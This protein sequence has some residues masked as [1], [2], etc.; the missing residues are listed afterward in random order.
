[1]KRGNL[2]IKNVLVY[3]HISLWER[4]LAMTLELVLKLRNQGHNVFLVL[5]QSELHACPANPNHHLTFC[6]KCRLQSKNL[7]ETL[8]PDDVQIVKLLDNL[9][10]VKKFHVHDFENQKGF[11]NLTHREAPL[12]HLVLSQLVDDVSDLKISLG[13]LRTR[14]IELLNMAVNLFDWSVDTLERLNIDEVYVW[15]GRRC[16]DGPVLHAAGLLGIAK[17][18]F[19]SGATQDRIF[20][21][22]NALHSL[23]EWRRS[24]DFFCNQHSIETIRKL[25]NRFFVDQASNKNPFYGSEGIMNVGEKSKMSIFTSTLWENF[26]LPEFKSLPSDFANPYDLIERVCLDARLVEQFDIT[27]RWHPNLVS[28]GPYEQDEI[29][30][31]MKSTPMVHHLPPKSEVNSYSLL[32]I[33]DLVVSTGSTIGIEATY[34]GKPSILLGTAI[35][36]GLDAVF[37]PKSYEEFIELVSGPIY[38]KNKD[39]ALKYGAFMAG[40]GKRLTFV[41]YDPILENFSYSNTGVFGK[42]S[43]IFKLFEL[44]KTITLNVF[45]SFTQKF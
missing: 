20:T 36:S 1:M 11:E 10:S 18:C 40:F 27:V 43:A 5:C 44:I 6:A 38:S 28:A 7:V 17:Y 21:Q 42:F 34:F 9:K 13:M 15:N 23:T 2:S 26:N 12:G 29:R 37:E 22:A 8:L 3:S 39:Q 25:G 14:G 41:N 33:S 35:Y 4:Q 24:I 32:E 16:S 45:K 30:R 31:V 19:I